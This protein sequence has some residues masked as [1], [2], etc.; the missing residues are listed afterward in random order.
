MPQQE[1]SAGASGC[2][3]PRGLRGRLRGSASGVCGVVLLTLLP[4]CGGGRGPERSAA[5]ALALRNQ[6]LALLESDR[7]VEAGRALEAAARGA[8]NDG[9]TA[10]ALGRVRAALGDLDGARA[11][12]Q[13]ARGL[14]ALDPALLAEAGFVEE[15]LGDRE[16][17]LALYRAALAEDPAHAPAHLRLAQL[18]DRMGEPEAAA[19]ALARFEHWT[20]LAAARAAA[21]AA[22][23]AAP[24]DLVLGLRAAEAE[25]ALGEHAAALARCEGLLE[26]DPGNVD[27]LRL[28]GR[29]AAAIGDFHAA[30]QRLGAAALRSPRDGELRIE[31]AE[32]LVALGERERALASAIEARDRGASAYQVG[33]IARAVGDAD[34]ALRWF[35][36]HLA[37]EPEDLDVR[38]A[39]AELLIAAARYDEAA[40]LYREV[41]ARDPEHDGARGSLAYVE[42]LQRSTPR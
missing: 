16:E 20:A 39:K 9:V 41:L 40:A 31:H 27:T 18:H 38:L 4:A 22:L 11:A 10:A 12:F 24:D 2:R 5:E 7:I 30:E 17:A 6:G 33:C 42:R 13:L 15:Q 37:A 32:V 28:A 23:A 14:G 21:V 3:S 1:H 29:A 25:A 8:P 36:E 35:D 26:R 34:G 19:E